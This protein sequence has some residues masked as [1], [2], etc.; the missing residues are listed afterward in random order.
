MFSTPEWQVLKQRFIGGSLAGVGTSIGALDHAVC[1]DVANGPR[2]TLKFTNFLVTHAHSDHA[3]G[4]PYIV[5]QKAMGNATRPRFHIP[6][7]T[8]KS[9]TTI[10]AEW[11][12][13]ED[14]EMPFELIGVAPNA[15]IKLSDDLRA[16]TFRTVHRVPSLGYTL[17][18]KKKKL[19]A[20]FVGKHPA[21]IVQLKRD[22]VATDEFI[23]SPEISFTGD[24]QIEVLENY[25]ELLSSRIL[26][27]EVTYYDDAKSVAETRKWGHTHFSEMQPYLKHF[28]GEKIVF[29]H[30]SARYRGHQVADI[31][32]SGAG[33]FFDKIFFAPSLYS[34]RE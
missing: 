27:F 30:H 21:E 19:K 16:Q 23:E 6:E 28:K 31:A 14:Y 33:E 17:Y 32:R 9:L 24:T 15:S 26:F 12:K 22:G 13:L 34:N 11:Q 25:P 3:S 5:S 7:E 2:H 4:I 1:F 20:E 18:L 10:M 8:V 29:I